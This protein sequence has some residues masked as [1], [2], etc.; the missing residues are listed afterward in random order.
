MRMWKHRLMH[1]MK[2]SFF[3][4]HLKTIDLY[5]NFFYQKLIVLFIMTLDVI[6][7]VPENPEHLIYLGLVVP[8]GRR[9]EP[10]V[11]ITDKL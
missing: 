9:K 10:Q 11:S 8:D 2:R 5:S 1:A 3:E 4:D 6:R 7:L